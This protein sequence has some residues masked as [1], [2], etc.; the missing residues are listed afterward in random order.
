MRKISDKI[1]K[2][3]L[4]SIWYGVLHVP[5]RQQLCKDMGEIFEKA[6]SEDE[7]NSVIAI[8]ST[9]TAPSQT[10]LTFNMIKERPDEIKKA[11]FTALCNLW[12]TK[13]VRKQWK[14]KWFCL[15]SKI[16]SGIPTDGDLRPLCLLD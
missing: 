9:N 5:K 2:E 15:K 7:F 13:E 16:D 1:P 4:D 3:A 10:G 11:I 12:S 8:S 6:I 14:W